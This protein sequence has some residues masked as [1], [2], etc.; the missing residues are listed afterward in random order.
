VKHSIGS[1][2]AVVRATGERFGR[3]VRTVVGG[4]IVFGSM[5]SGPA[6]VGSAALLAPI[7]SSAG[8][9]EMTR[10]FEQLD[11]PMYSSP[12]PVRQRLVKGHL[13]DAIPLWIRALEQ[14]RNEMKIAAA[15]AIVR[16]QQS[17]MPGLGAATDALLA[18]YERP[19]AD[20]RR[21]AARA[22][23]AI[24]ARAA[25]PAFER[26]LDRLP[27]TIADWTEQ[28]L[29]SWKSEPAKAVWRRRLT[30]PNVRTPDLR[31]AVAG[32]VAAEDRDS[33]PSLR[34]IVLD[35]YRGLGDR[36]TAA[37]GLAQLSRAGE[38][39][40]AVALLEAGLP[41][42][43]L[44]AATLVSQHGTEASGL[45][46]RIA[47]QG[48]DAAGVIAAGR[49]R[50]LDPKLLFPIGR[51][52]TERKD[53][54]LRR[55]GIVALETRQ[56][57]EDVARLLEMFADLHPQVRHDA[58][59]ACER[60]ASVAEHRPA[61]A[62][63]V[64][65]IAANRRGPEHWRVI[66]QSCVCIGNLDLEENTAG[67][68]GLLDETRPE[69]S[70]SAAW[71]LGK[72]DVEATYAPVAEYCGRQLDGYDR[73][74]LPRPYP[75]EVMSHLLQLLGSARYEPSLSMMTRL[76]PKGLYGI[77][78]RAA[79]IWS[80]GLLLEEKNDPAIAQRLAER[81]LDGAGIP[82]EADL[83]RRM[84]AISLG[85]MRSVEQVANI[86]SIASGGVATELGWS[87]AWALSTIDGRAIPVADP[88]VRTEI[89]W[90][91]QPLDAEPVPE[92]LENDAPAGDGEN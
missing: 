78:S 70:C 26:D 33:I 41:G 47:R 43:D 35:R 32:L 76:I 8:A 65:D 34:Q 62:A 49:L 31:R 84:S 82:P 27:E 75:D 40:H 4:S 74:D 77:E 28:G 30:E 52:L 55:L 88:Y 39:P 86:E 59:Q 69:S 46:E 24:D 18:C 17:G 73:K 90:F 87:A 1:E 64:A 79:A 12:K 10:P 61:I 89:D 16:A 66:E 54:E 19:E 5:F 50:E 9:D 53:R 44:L 83:V 81:M 92:P 37:R 13:I 15:D 22:L 25:M 29:A 42:N 48:I 57:T 60:L 91:L 11:Q 14:D 72:L 38:E 36:L 56:S 6:I 21:A 68:I 2:F 20:V 23:V 51:E 67:L 85:R 58:R 3:L 63:F 80:I 7:V 45:L 71:A